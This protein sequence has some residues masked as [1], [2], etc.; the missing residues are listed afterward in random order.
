MK[1]FTLTLLLVLTVC[2]AAAQTLGGSL[3]YD[4]KTRSW[5]PVASVKLVTLDDLNLKGVT[6]EVRLLA[7]IEEA[8]GLAATALVF[9]RPIGSKL[10]LEL[11]AAVR[12]LANRQPSFGIV[13]GA[14]VKF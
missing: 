12:I 6:A 13:L 5:L 14:S 8:R 9:S 11:G 10:S 2:M 1:R 3:L 7:G 4:F